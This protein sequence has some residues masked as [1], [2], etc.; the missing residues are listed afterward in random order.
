LK[1][2]TEIA[3]LPRLLVAV[4]RAADRHGVPIDVRGSATGVLYAGMPASAAPEAAAAVVGDLRAAAT[5]YAGSVVVLT[6]PAAIREVL[7]VWGPVPG[8]D[9]MRRVK[10][11][12]DPE[13]RLSPGRFV[14]GI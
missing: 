2:T 5:T 6:A 11:Q 8:L 4:R 3:G 7:D 9:L 13:H 10:D 14:G 1:L 12:L